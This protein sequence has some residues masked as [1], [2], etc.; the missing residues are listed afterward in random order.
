MKRYN[1]ICGAF[2][3][4]EILLI[5][6]IVLTRNGIVRPTRI[7][8]V[9]GFSIFALGLFLLIYAGVHLWRANRSKAEAGVQALA[10]GGPYRLVR[11]PYY[12]GDII[13]IV[14]LAVG[15]GSVWGLAGTL[16]LL[17]PSAIYVARLEDE[18]LAEKFGDE[19]RSFADRTYFMF[20]PVY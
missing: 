17:I 3:G 18:T 6:L 11:H 7:L 5:V 9:V 4:L 14:G 15:L 16:F 13:L 2:N 1:L 20:P 12:L 19:W 10:T 8:P